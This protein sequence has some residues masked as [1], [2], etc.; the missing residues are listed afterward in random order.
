MTEIVR[1]AKKYVNGLLMPLEN[2]YYHQYAH[3]IE[4]MDRC[5]Y[6]S[7]KEWLNKEEIEM[8]SLAW[9]FH[10]TWFIIQYDDNEIIWAKIAKNFLRTLLYPEEKIKKIEKIILATRPSYKSPEN[11]YEKIIKD[12]DLDNLWTNDFFSKWS[13]LKKEIESIKK[14]KIKEPLWHHSSLD[15]LYD[16]K[17]YTATQKNERLKQKLEN[18]KKLEKK[19]KKE[20][21]NKNLKIKY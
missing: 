18:Q 16:H 20:S 13:N 21:D 1:K 12:S 17:Y 7:K 6:L 10:D 11:I 2:H 4:V 14:I 5:I 15:L 3:A 19:V 9:L 8:M